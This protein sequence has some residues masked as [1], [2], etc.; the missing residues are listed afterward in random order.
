MR[1]LVTR[2]EPDAS[3]TAERLR[4]LGHHPIVAP[5]LTVTFIPPPPDLQ[6]P[7][8]IIVTS[9]N[10][11]RALSLWPDGAHWDGVP[12]YGLGSATG[13]T[14]GGRPIT[15]A[16]TVGTGR[17][18]A[19]HIAGDIPVGRG[20]LLYIAGRD[21]AGELE[22]LLAAVRYDVRVVEA[23]RAD[24]VQE[25]PR[26]A[27][28]AL[29]A[30]DIDGVLLYSRR[31]A[32]TYLR[33]AEEAGISAALRRPAYY[34]ISDRVADLLGPSYPRVHVAGI[35]NEDNLLALIPAPR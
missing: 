2:P 10:G 32:E 4:A 21:R 22:S 35:P 23:Y 16:V 25:F 34:V 7:S 20:Q 9:G 18:L 31:S 27:K 19:E 13:I 3:A 29:S 26:A 12:V 5:L 14:V 11:V 15:V 28:V 6:K 1:L 33:L 24:P 17:D 30:G 8:A